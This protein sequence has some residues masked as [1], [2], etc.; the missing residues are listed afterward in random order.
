ML[1]EAQLF[2]CL[3]Y[4]CRNMLLDGPFRELGKTRSTLR[5]ITKSSCIKK[6]FMQRIKIIN[7]TDGTC[8]QEW[9]LQVQHFFLQ[10][11]VN[12]CRKGPVLELKVV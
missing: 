9:M 10:G 6:K 7:N 2:K 3:L 11:K 5:F 4:I 12:T 8:I 1:A